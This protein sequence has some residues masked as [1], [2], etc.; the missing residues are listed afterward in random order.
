LLN[1]I[2]GPAVK[3]VADFGSSSKDKK[4]TGSDSFGK[5]LEEKNFSKAPKDKESVGA[6]KAADSPKPVQD[7]K[8]P[9]ESEPKKP[10]PERA[11]AK[12]SVKESSK[13]TDGPDK[14]VKGKSQREQAILK[15]M[16]SFESEFGVPPTR[17][18]E[19]MAT[20]KQ[21]EQVQSPEET[22]DQVIDQLGLK[23]DEKDPAKGMYIGLLAQL[24]QLE[25]T[26]PP[27]AKSEMALLGSG[28]KGRFEEVQAQKGS[29]NQSLQ[30][31]NEKFWMNGSAAQGSA[32]SG[33]AEVSQE[34]GAGLNHL[35]PMSD[36]QAQIEANPSFKI[37]PSKLSPQMQKA[38]QAVKEAN[39]TASPEVA[40]AALVAAARA[41]SGRVAGEGSEENDDSDVASTALGAGAAATGKEFGNAEVL[42]GKAVPETVTAYEDPAAGRQKGFQSSQQGNQQES[43]LGSKTTKG[44]VA[45]KDK[46]S[47]SSDFDSTLRMEGMP[48]P[49][50][51]KDLGVQA[52]G[53]SPVVGGGIGAASKNEEPADIRQ[54]MNQ[55]QYLIKKG[56]GEM[57]VEMTPEGMGKVHMKVLVENGKVNIQMSAETNEAKKVIEGGLSELKNSL[58][59]HQLSM[60]HIKVDVVSG[61]NTDNTAQNQ[62]NQNHQGSREQTRQ[63]WNGFNESF[64]S[65]SQQRENFT[66]IPSLKGYA[67]PRTDKPLEPIRNARAANYDVTG[68]GKGLNLV[69]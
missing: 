27:P 51:L 1:S 62:L 2:V 42:S 63:F 32:S 59:A 5:V 28:S 49:T 33:K 30:S 36:L 26:P 60:D 10:E 61:T 9:R 56:G 3:G 67:R 4:G 31:M 57:K 20:L 41:Q 6:N 46:V 19:A 65:P 64:G 50:P 54:I 39:P 23:D 12:E 11:T 35:G 43:S 40:L 44:E 48:T 55:A 53:Q 15:F 21:D 37:D 29:L 38:L 16:D 69:A 18:V 13:E 17:I 22:A 58:A 7:I 25:R 66:D 45:A 47:K 14:N 68:K 8:Q 34:L 24:G 52:T